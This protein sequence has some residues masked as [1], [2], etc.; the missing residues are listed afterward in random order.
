MGRERFISSHL[1]GLVF[2]LCVGCSTWVAWQPCAAEHSAR[3]NKQTWF[4]EVRRLAEVRGNSQ[5]DGGRIQ[6]WRWLG[7]PLLQILL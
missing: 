7:V 5:G 4:L 1:R 6:D 3:T 2:A